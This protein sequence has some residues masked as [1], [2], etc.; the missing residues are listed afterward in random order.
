MFQA[1]SQLDL[2]ALTVKHNE[3]VCTM[4]KM[5]SFVSVTSLA[6]RSTFNGHGLRPMVCCR[7]QSAL[8]HRLHAR[9]S[10]LTTLRAVF[11]WS[12]KNEMFADDDS[13]GTEADSERESFDDD[14]DDVDIDDVDVSDDEDEDDDDE[15]DDEEDDEYDLRG[16][17]RSPDT[18]RHGFL[19]IDARKFSQPRNTSDFSP[20]NHSMFGGARADLGGSQTS[21][22][23][24][25]FGSS[26]SAG[27]RAFGEE[28]NVGNHLYDILRSYTAGPDDVSR[29]QSNASEC[30]MDA[31]RRTVLGIMGA[32][33]SDTY[34][35]AV[36]CD[37]V[38][39]WR[40][41]QSSLCTGYCLRNAEYRMSLNNTMSATAPQ[42]SSGTHLSTRAGRAST[43]G[44]TNVS[45]PPHAAKSVPAQHESEGHTPSDPTSPSAS[46]SPPS[47]SAK[48]S[49][50]GSKDRPSKDRP[51]KVNRSSSTSRRD[52]SSEPDYMRSVPFRGKV[53]SS[54]VSGIVKWWDNEHDAMKEMS[55]SDYV[56]K[57]EAEVEILRD[58]LDAVHNND[59][60]NGNRLLEFMKT[61]SMDK[62]TGLTAGIDP[63]TEDCFTRVTKSVL[64]EVNVSKV[65]VQYSTSRDYLAHIT[66]WC[67]LVGYTLRNLEKRMEMQ[68]LFNSTESVAS[69]FMRSKS[70]PS[71]P[72][73][74]SSS[75]QQSPPSSP[76]TPPPSPSS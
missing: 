38:G 62:I 2:G 44:S 28:A 59:K 60:H 66:F 8:R 69:S 48:R 27:H 70:P 68:N 25:N 10:C 72:S 54:S 35:V 13:D 58:R 32:L 61:L 71:S 21:S 50:S 47:S 24:N 75:S 36:T 53:D 73:S 30:A 74:P 43:R 6:T 45:S 3:S 76:H 11:V 49:R 20:R 56:S 17:D 15:E 51:S 26:S 29:L 65:Q 31:F 19:E 34:D 57:L 7:P 33:P 55:A 4:N 1:V 22:A 16:D 52:S 40:L 46:A 63:V 41:M 37:R 9:V 14:I 5:M 39:F 42:N 64:G 12:N 67:L 18:D 23:G